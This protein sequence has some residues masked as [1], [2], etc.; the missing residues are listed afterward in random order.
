MSSYARMFLEQLSKPAVETID[1]I[2]PTVAIEQRT[3][4]ATPRSIVAT[5]TEIYDYLRLL[6]ARAGVPH[7]PICDRIIS[8]QSPDKIVERI[9]A[10]PA[11]SKL[12]IMA[13]MVRGKKGTHKELIQ[14]LQAEG[15]QRLRVNGAILEPGEV[16]PLPKTYK[17]SIEAVI[18]RL[19]IRDDVRSRV[20]D[21]VELA[22]KVAEGLVSIL[23]EPPD[24]GK[25]VEEIFSER[26]A[27]SVHG[28]ALEELSPRAF[29]F[30][31]PV[32]ACPTCSGIGKVLEPDE[33]LVVPDPN[34]T[35]RDGAIYAWTRCGG[36]RFWDTTSDYWS[37][38]AK[39]IRIDPDVPFKDLPKKEQRALLYGTD[40]DELEKAFGIPYEGVL[41]NLMRR[42]SETT[43]DAMRARINEFMSDQPCPA[44]NGR[45]LKPEILAVRI[46]EKDIMQVTE[47]S[48]ETALSFFE[49]L[50]FDA[51]KTEIARPIRKAVNERLGFLNNVGLGY[52]TLDRETN[53]L[54]GGE[55]QRI[56]LAT[57]VGTK[58][59]GVTYV[60]DE[61]TIGLHQRDNER[62]LDTLVE[63]R[64][65][66][67]TVLVV[68]HDNDV[69]RRADYLIDMG[70]LAGEH[71]G[72]IVA[73]GSPA[74][75]MKNFDSLTAKYLRG[76][77]SVKTPDRRRPV[78]LGKAITVKGAAENNLKGIDVSF[79]LGVFI[80]VTG[81]SGSGKSSL[82][83]ECLYKGLA[84]RLG[85]GRESP[86][87]HSSIIGYGQIDKIIDI[88]QSPIGRTPRSNPATYTGIFNDIRD[89]FALTREAKV[90]GYTAS[91]FSFNVKGGRCED[92]AGHGMKT[93]P[94]HFLPDVNVLCETCKGARYNR[95]TLQVKFKGLSIAEV[96]DMPVDVACG[97]FRAHPK[98]APG[99]ETLF[100]V[101]LGYIRLGQP[102][103]TLSGG[104]AQRIKLATELSRKT[105]GQTFYILDEPTTGL[106]FHDVA[107]LLEEIG[108]AHV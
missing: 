105:T 25:P 49:S 38:T 20:A 108:R 52:L 19:K 82:V 27:C 98:I 78:S 69:I 75:V 55:A 34:L 21:S 101:G 16:K 73:E 97:F 43:S 107:K 86:G 50:K 88:D 102:S 91:R 74:E 30:N 84:R 44:C 60:L 11:E 39:K 15:F 68:E 104:E 72:E 45:R 80:C 81:V 46:A 106:H 40:T 71:G 17:H 26:F 48:V 51:E 8:S 56:R 24:G 9:M 37:E 33:N 5:T 79:P 103:T 89:V 12:H 31:S 36:M 92:C 67:N 64:D 1:G 66:G 29:S 22:L 10:Y 14:H 13:P 18:D 76:D 2:T 94:M 83:N 61:P 65:L 7:C 54:S 41:P 99:L 63:L 93:I 95:E 47:M 85:V 100:D 3:G 53:T 35:L 96:L 62:L 58:M 70:P 6:Y 57:Q 87:Q 4:R 28:P 42:L 90:R 59:V 77:L 23:V 32:G